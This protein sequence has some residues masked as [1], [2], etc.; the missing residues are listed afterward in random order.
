MLLLQHISSETK[1]KFFAIWRSLTQSLPMTQPLTLCVYE[2]LLPGG[3][4]VNRL[5]DMGYRVQAIADPATLVEQAEREKPLLIMA[6]LEPRQ[7][8]VCE[9][10]SSLKKNSATSHIPIIA[11]APARN[12]AVQDTARTAG[13]TLVVNDSAILVHLNQF[14]EQALQVD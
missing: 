9:A 5:Q 3:Q 12:A 8:Q 7:Q 1:R 13:A 10:I 14:L 6:D 11:F 2:R 4:L